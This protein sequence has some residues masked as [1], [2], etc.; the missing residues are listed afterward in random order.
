MRAAREAEQRAQSDLDSAVASSL[1]PYV[2]ER[3]RLIVDRQRVT[4]AIRE[5]ET[6]IGWHESLDQRQLE[7]GR[8]EDQISR[9][10][11]EIE[12]RLDAQISRD[13]LIETL[14]GRFQA[15]LSD[16]RFPKL[17]DPSPPYLNKS[18][19]P[20]VRGVSYRDIGSA[21]A[22]TLSPWLGSCLCSNSLWRRATPT[23]G[24]S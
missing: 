19:V 1:S 12:T 21:G 3:D 15:I 8:L 10:R 22:M 4:D 13:E 18:F 2:S 11:S 17:D 5:I 24:S 7:I 14:T 9:L 20:H 23:R 16:F 6:Q